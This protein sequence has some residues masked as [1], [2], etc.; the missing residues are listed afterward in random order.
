MSDNRRPPPT[1]EWNVILRLAWRAAVP[2]LLLLVLLL[3][4]LAVAKMMV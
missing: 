2:F 3:A 4:L 1:V